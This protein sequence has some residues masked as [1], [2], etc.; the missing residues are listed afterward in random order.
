MWTAI[1]NRFQLP[2]GGS[3]QLRLQVPQGMANATINLTFNDPPAG[4][5][6]ANI[7]QTGNTLQVLLKAD[8]KTS[9]GIAG[10]LILEASTKN[11][12]GKPS[13]PETLP[14]VPF[15]VVSQHP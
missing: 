3:G 12:A 8:V 10:N 7:S 15:E 5:G 2:I 14:A 11:G 1:A 9:R 4:I 13:P 6:I